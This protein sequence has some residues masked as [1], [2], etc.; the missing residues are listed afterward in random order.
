M[1]AASIGDGGGQGKIF[2]IGFRSTNN[3]VYGFGGDD[4]DT[5][6]NHIETSWVHW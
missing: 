6:S 2:H 4:F 3:F 1:Y 5:T